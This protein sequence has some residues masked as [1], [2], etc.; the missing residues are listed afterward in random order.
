[1]AVAQQSALTTLGLQESE[2]KREVVSSLSEG[3]VPVYEAAK[4]FKSLQASL[5]AKAVVG[6]LA[7][8]K[9]YTTS[10]AFLA[11]YEKQ[12]ESA[13]PA[14]PPAKGSVDVEM[15]KQRT[16]RRKGLEEMKQN[17]AKMPPDMQKS[18]AATVKQMEENFAKMDSDPQMAAMMRQGI[19]MQRAEEQKRHQEQLAAYNKQWPADPKQLIARRLQEFLDISKDVDYDAQLFTDRGKRKFVDSKYESKPANWKLCF[20]AG[21]ETTEAAR[22]FA[23]SWLKELQK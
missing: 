13:K 22:A 5:K 9:A 15:A 3:R 21:K 16:E 17:V 7:W 19:E 1:V 23:A 4:A 20:R 6:V 10:P 2:A 11:D 14:A 12:R 8:A 18:M